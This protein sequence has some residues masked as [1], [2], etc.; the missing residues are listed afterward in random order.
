MAFAIAGLAAAGETT[1]RDAGAAAV[2]FPEFFDILG[3]VCE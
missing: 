2:S 3:S 1:I